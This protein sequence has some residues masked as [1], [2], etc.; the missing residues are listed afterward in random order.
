MAEPVYSKGQV[1]SA[2]KHVMCLGVIKELNSDACLELLYRWNAEARAQ[3]VSKDQDPLSRTEIMNQLG[4]F[5]KHIAEGNNL[6]KFGSTRPM[7]EVYE[8]EVA[9]LQITIGM[10]GK[11]A[12]VCDQ[13]LMLLTGSSALKLLGLRIRPGRAARQPCAKFVEEAYLATP[14]CD[15]S[16]ARLKRNGGGQMSLRGLTGN[17]CLGIVLIG[18]PSFPWLASAIPPTT[19]M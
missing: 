8:S 2:L 15:W 1:T 19:A 14:Y 5:E 17:E 18:S 11:T 12:D 6:A 7:A 4:L 16:R 3:E 9:P 10:R 13:A